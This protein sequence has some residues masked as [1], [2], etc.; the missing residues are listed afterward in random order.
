MRHSRPAA[1]RLFQSAAEAYGRR[2]IGVVLTGG[3]H[4][5]TDGLKAIKAAGGI[6]VV[7]QPYEAQDPSMPRSALLGDHPDH[8][9]PID[10]EMGALFGQAGH[11]V[12]Q[13]DHAHGR[14]WDAAAGVIRN[15]A[16]T[17]G[18][19]ATPAWKMATPP[20]HRSD[21]VRAGMMEDQRYGSAGPGGIVEQAVAGTMEVAVLQDDRAEPSGRPG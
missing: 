11:G 12:G 6:S 15:G 3:G 2:V 19:A 4:D 18:T 9:A 13:L 1:D 14:V 16:M 20:W 10:E 21:A 17:R 8:C 5:G 7:Q